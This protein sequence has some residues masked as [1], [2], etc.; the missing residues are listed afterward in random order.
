VY[1]SA[2]DVAVC[3]CNCWKRGI[4]AVVL[5]VS[6]NLM[7]RIKLCVIPLIVV[8]SGVMFVA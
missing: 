2:L 6:G 5:R 8:F 7:L 1:N 4:I 3:W